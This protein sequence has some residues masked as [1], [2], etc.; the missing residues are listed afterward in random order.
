[1][2]PVFLDTNVVLRHLLADHPKQSPQATA[3]LNKVEQ[4]KIKVVT[5]D[6]VIFEVVYTLERHYQHSKAAIREALLPLIELTGI[7]LPG[8]RRLRRV[9]NLYVERNLPFADA[10]HTVLMKSLKTSTIVSFDRDF[11]HLPGIKRLNP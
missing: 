3:F 10:Y 8:K 11:D 5:A 1:M 7:V 9:F 2:A 6:T 4:G